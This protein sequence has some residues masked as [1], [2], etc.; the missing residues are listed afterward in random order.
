MRVAP[1][2]TQVTEKWRNGTFRPYM[3]YT[4]EGAGVGA[5]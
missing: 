5:M 1:E 4:L 3:G 2:V